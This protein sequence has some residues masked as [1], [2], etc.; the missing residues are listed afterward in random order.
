MTK[1]QLRTLVLNWK[2]NC[3]IKK[4]SE[5]ESKISQ[6]TQAKHQLS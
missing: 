3:Q 2:D 6:E 5:V 1:T 4:K